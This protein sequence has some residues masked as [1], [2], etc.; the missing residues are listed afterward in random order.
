LGKFFYVLFSWSSSGFICEMT[1]E[2]TQILTGFSLEPGQLKE[3]NIGDLAI[4]RN[5]LKECINPLSQCSCATTTKLAHKI[6]DFLNL[7]TDLWEKLNESCTPD[8]DG[9]IPKPR[10]A[11]LADAQGLGTV[12]GK[13]SEI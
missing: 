1:H 7:R 12:E 11:E 2:S 6:R 5:L 8:Y 13:S 4:M 3:I 10:V 9:Y